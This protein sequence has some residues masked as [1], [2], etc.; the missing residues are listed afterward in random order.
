MKPLTEAQQ[1]LVERFGVLHDAM[2]MRPAAGRI[3]GLLFVAAEGE[4]TF[5]TFESLE[6][7]PMA[8]DPTNPDENQ[9]L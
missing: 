6:S 3:L 4:L 2:G 7:D 5:E 9:G 1:E 8:M